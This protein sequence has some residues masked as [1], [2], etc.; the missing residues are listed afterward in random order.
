[1]LNCREITR[2][3]SESQDR[4][5]TLGEK[6]SLRTHVIMCSG[7]RNYE[8]NMTSL[9]LATRAFAQGANE[10]NINEPKSSDEE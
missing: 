1:M 8:K 2:L 7:C 5:L 4:P 3:V 9:R 10:Q 6:L